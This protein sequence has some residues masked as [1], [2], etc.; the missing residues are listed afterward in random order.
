MTERSLNFPTVFLLRRYLPV[1]F[2]QETR[3]VAQRRYRP[4]KLLARFEYLDIINIT[5]K[6]FELMS[7]VL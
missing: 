2:F 7:F 5:I 6:D 3:W 4:Q 1:I